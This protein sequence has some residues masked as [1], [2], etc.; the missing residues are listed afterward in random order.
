MI[1][2]WKEVKERRLDY[3]VGRIVQFVNSIMNEMVC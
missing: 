2:R 3:V 1:L